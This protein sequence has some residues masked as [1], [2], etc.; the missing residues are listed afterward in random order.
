MN[1]NMSSRDIHNGLE[2]L[3]GD[4]HRIYFHVVASLSFWLL[5]NP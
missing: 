1:Y 3:Y 2:Y 5:I 4:R